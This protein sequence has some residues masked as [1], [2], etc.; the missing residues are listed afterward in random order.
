MQIASIIVLATLALTA[1][2]H[3]GGPWWSDI[4]PHK[5]Q[6]LEHHS[7]SYH[8]ALKQLGAAR[9]A[10][11]PLAANQS[12]CAV[13]QAIGKDIID[14]IMNPT[15]VNITE[16]VLRGVCAKYA[17]THKP[18]CDEI[19]RKVVRLGVRLVTKLTVELKFNI[20]NVFCADDFKLCVDDCCTTATVPEQIRLNFASRQAVAND[21]AMRV[22]WVTLKATSDATVEYRAV[23][24]S[25]WVTGTETS[26]TYPLGGW[27]GVIHTAVMTGLTPATT[28]TYRVGSVAH[29]QSPIINFTTLPLNA[30]TAERPLRV[31]N[32]ADM[33]ILNSEHTIASMTQMVNNG[34]IDF[35]LHPGDI[36][37]ADGD[38]KRWD[39]FGR[40]MQPIM[41][42]VAYMTTPGNHECMYNFTAYKHRYQMQPVTEGYPADAMYYHFYVGPVA[43]VMVDSETFINTPDIGPV[44]VRWI[45]EELSTAKQLKKF[46]VVAQHRPLYSTTFGPNDQPMLLRKQ[47]ERAYTSHQVGIVTCGHLH[48]YERTFPVTDNVTA[49]RD[50][51]MTSAPVYLIN[52]AAGNREG[53]HGFNSNA[54][55]SA[56]RSSDVG[57]GLLTF[58]GSDLV[59]QVNS[60]FI[61]SRTHEVIDEFTM[62]KKL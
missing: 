37:Y 54:A 39:M 56:A 27:V 40:L 4:L 51:A 60:K 26:T 11:R 38:E 14:I 29:G 36:G 48:S 45:N 3:G 32:I 61:Q 17:P 7:D 43:F 5:W 8:D 2:A 9:A 19:V 55:W 15:A 42:R 13:C 30:G 58:S 24:E 34:S 12:V 41:S 6:D 47:A 62:T 31:L 20:P 28:Y 46:I 52:G 49:S 35:V 18:L 57:F 1:S 16:D 10:Q 50:Y 21:T 25:E 59:M 53:N 22:T 23:D 44:E 33:G